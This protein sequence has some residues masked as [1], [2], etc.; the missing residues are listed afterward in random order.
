METLE[1]EQELG[2][3]REGAKWTIADHQRGEKFGQ[4]ETDKKK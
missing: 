4:G 2:Q 3:E 1:H